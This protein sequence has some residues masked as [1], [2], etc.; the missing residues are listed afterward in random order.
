MKA[1][2]IAV[3][4]GD[5]AGIGPE[6]VVSSWNQFAANSVGRVVVGSPPVIARAVELLRSPLTVRT[7]RDCDEPYDS[8]REIG[9]VPIDVD[10]HQL[11]ACCRVDRASGEAA[12]QSLRLACRLALDHR[13]AG[14]VTAPI[15]KQSLQLAGH[16]FPGHTELLAEWCGSD[17]FA[18]MLY[19]PPGA[20]VSGEL[21]LGVVHTTLHIP[22]RDVF[23]RLTTAAILEKCEL[24]VGFVRALLAARGFH[25][26]E[27]VVVTALNPH[28]GEA[29]LFGD[30][31]PRLIAPAVARAQSLGW[32]VSGPLPTDTLMLRAA[33]GE[34]DAVVAMYH[35][36]GHIALK[37][38]GM[39][40]AVNVTLG[41][42]IVRTSVAHG[43]AFDIA[44]QGRADPGS[45]IAAIRLSVEL[46]S[47]AALTK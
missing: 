4:M 2:L 13:V 32:H 36:Q 1:P 27:R 46:A 37:L 26:A 41:L 20:G 15:N 10:P 16:L 19:L 30:E 22:L 5:P 44:W 14:I 7:L 3:T 21:G 40:R 24:A 23:A 33:S 38:L 28:G 17:R 11:T 45:L 8:R 25:R 6:I 39:H 43:T 18:M 12:Y 42:P 34:F 29:G 47:Q 9:V 31:E 35:D